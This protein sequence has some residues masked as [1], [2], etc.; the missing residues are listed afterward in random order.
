MSSKNFKNKVKVSI[1]IGSIT[2]W[3]IAGGIVC[4]ILGNISL[5]EWDEKN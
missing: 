1:N 2:K 3:I 5:G 4:L